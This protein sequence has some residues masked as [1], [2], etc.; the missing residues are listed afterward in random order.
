MALPLPDRGIVFAPVGCGDSTTV[1]IDADTIVLIDIHHVG[2][3]EDDDDPRLPIVDEL[4]DALPKREGK[5]YLAAFGATHLDTDHICGFARL[6]DEA[7]IGDLWFTPRVLW[8]QDDLC[9]DAKAFRDEAE[10]RIKKLKADG[11]VGSGDRIRIIG[12]HDSLKEHSDIYENLPEGA[13]TVPGSEF[14]AIDG[15]DFDGTFRAFVHAPFKEDGD[16]DRN[17][18]SFGLQITLSDGDADFKA[19]VLGDLAYPTVNRIFERSDDEDLEFDVFLGP[20]HCSKS[21]MYWQGPDDDEAKLQQ[22]LLDKIEAAAR[23]GAYIVASS[24]PIPASNNVGDN[25]PHAKAAARYREI[26]DDEHFVCTGEHPTE[27]APEPLVFELT[28]TGVALRAATAASAAA[29]SVAKA[30]SEARGS[31]RPPQ[32]PVGFGRPRA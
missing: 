1:A 19:I 10:R 17:D 26:V 32:Q 16:K 6:L 20:H 7:T 25:P 3:S 8:D 29:S 12:Y 5:P 28:A 18:T 23:V 24:G 30:V 2:D 13:V 22:G 9:D 11:D 27:D 4:I 31:T 14:T 21:V 15:E